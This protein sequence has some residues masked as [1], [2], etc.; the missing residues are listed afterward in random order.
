M[1]IFS[2]KIL[3]LTFLAAILISCSDSTPSINTVSAILVFDFKDNESVPEQ[4]LSVFLQTDDINRLEKININNE[5]SGLEWNILKP[6]LISSKEDKSW[7]G[8]TNLAPASNSSIPSGRYYIRYED[9]AQKECSS[10]FN[11]SYQH[12]FLEKKAVDFPA[13][14]S[15]S[16]SQYYAVYSSDKTLLGYE[17]KKKNWKIDRDIKIDYPMADTYRICYSMNNNSVVIMMPENSFAE[18]TE[19]VQNKDAADNETQKAVENNIE[20]KDMEKEGE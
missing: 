4:K 5:K 2:R 16:Y 12:D 11:V 10:Q 13:A 15:G 1:K 20:I 3:F 17:R 8:Y 14:I 18:K 6:R 7:A 19:E 9:A